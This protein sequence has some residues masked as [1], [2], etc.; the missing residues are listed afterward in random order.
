MTRAA[1]HASELSALLR[2]AGAEAIEIPTVAI[3]D[4]PGG[5]E[6]L[7]QACAAIDSFDWI[8]F[9]SATAVERVR[10][11]IEP[12]VAKW[13]ARVASVGRAT[14]SALSPR[15]AELV[16]QGATGSALVEAFPAGSGRVLL[17][18]S[19][20]AGPTVADGIRAKG[21]TVE[22]VAAYTTVTLALDDRALSGAS[23]A[24]A[25]CFISASSV[26]GW[27]AGGGAEL[28]PS[29]VITIGPSTSAA[30]A[31]AGLSVTVEATE[32]S[33]GGVVDA[34]VLH[35]GSGYAG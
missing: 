13:S 22:V 25:I 33:L 34:L 6:P 17:P 26:R 14:A 4:P 12:D 3:A 9:T 1:P 20:I 21:W 11:M 32:R 23:T 8:V 24:Q 18:Q 30:A 2:S 7:Q 35:R 5:F 27:V 31:A 19:A 29:V 10:P 15:Q 28:T 16:A